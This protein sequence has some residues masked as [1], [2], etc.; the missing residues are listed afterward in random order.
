MVN[1]GA[2]EVPY[3][4]V[5]GDDAAGVTAAVVISSNWGTGP[6]CTW[7]GQRISPRPD[8]DKRI[9][10]GLQ[11]ASRSPHQVVIAPALTVDLER[12]RWMSS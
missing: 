8:P 12:R 5:T 6:C 11:S 4:L 10:R 7:P 9:H 1:R 3:P 2:V